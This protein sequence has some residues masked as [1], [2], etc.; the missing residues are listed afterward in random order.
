M[1]RLPSDPSWYSVASSYWQSQPAT[2]DGVLGGFSRLSETDISASRTFL[3]NL[4]KAYPMLDKRAV[5]DCGAGIGRVSQKLL[6]NFGFKDVDLLEPSPNLIGQAKH[7]LKDSIRSYLEIGL[8]DWRPDLIEAHNQKY[9]IIWAQWVLLY[10]TDEDLVLFFKL[11]SG[12]KCEKSEVMIILKENV[13]STD[14]NII[15]KEDNS[16]S[17]TA[18]EYKRLA[19]EAGLELVMEMKQPMWP[20]DLYPVVMMAFRASLVSV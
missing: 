3:T 6:L 1:K 14:E 17:R 18:S 20:S 5:L 15:D 11:A 16:I 9:S 19:G 4:Y 12:D 2:V 7:D 8:Q 13:S 10:L